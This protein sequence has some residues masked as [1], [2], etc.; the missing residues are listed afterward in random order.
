MAFSSA[1]SSVSGASGVAF[2]ASSVRRSAR[3]TRRGKS[4]TLRR[5]TTRG[6]ATN[7]RTGAVGIVENSGRD[8]KEVTGLRT[9]DV[10]KGRSALTSDLLLSFLLRNDS[11]RQRKRRI[12]VP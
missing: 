11:L 12:G 4:E 5:R 10:A 6:C 8:F 3:G 7:W 1:F 2:A 9:A